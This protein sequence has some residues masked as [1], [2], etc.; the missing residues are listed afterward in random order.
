MARFL[1]ARGDYMAA[2]SEYERAEKKSPG[3]ERAL[4]GIALVHLMENRLSEAAEYMNKILKARPG[5]AYPFGILGAIADELRNPDDAKVLYDAAMLADPSEAAAY[6]RKAQ[7]L[8]GEGLEK[9]CAD[10][11]RECAKVANPRTDTPMATERLNYIF[12][13]VKA[14]RAPM[15]RAADS[16]A[17]V[18]G[19]GDLLDRAVGDEIPRFRISLEDVKLGGTKEKADAIKILSEALEA[20][21]DAGPLCVLGELLHDIGRTSDAIDCYERAM[22][23][24][25][26]DMMH[27]VYK[28]G[29]LQD[30]GDSAGAAKC[31]DEALE[32]APK[33]EPNAQ[34]QKMLRLRRDTP[35]K[36]QSSFGAE[37]MS[38]AVRWHVARRKRFPPQAGGSMLRA[39]K[40]AR[41]PG[42]TKGRTAERGGASAAFARKASLQMRKRTDEHSDK[43]AKPRR[44]ERSPAKAS[45]AQD[46]DAALTRAAA[47]FADDEPDEALRE[48]E[49]A[50][51]QSP[52]DERVLCGMALAHMWRGNRDKIADCVKQ[53]LAVRPGA[54]YPHGITGIFVDE[55]GSHDFAVR[56][57]DLMIAADPGEVSA[58]VRKAMI[59]RR[60]GMEKECADAIKE[61]LAARWS[62]RESPKEKRRLREMGENVA[63]G[64]RIAFKTHDSGTFLPGMWEMLDLAFGPDRAS[65][66][67]PDGK[68][69]FEGIRLAGEGDFQAG[70]EWAEHAFGGGPESALTWSTKGML[71]AEDGRVDEA[72]SCYERAAELDP[73]GTLPYSCKANLLADEGNLK[74]ARECIREALSYAPPNPACASLQE[75]LAGVLKL[76]DSGGEWPQVRSSQVMAGRIRWAAG[77]RSK[78]PGGRGSSRRRAAGA[79][80]IFPPGLAGGAGRRKSGRLRAGRRR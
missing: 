41:D 44:A 26:G 15:I 35:D 46:P 8:L 33:D 9:E 13:S 55:L 14:G 78:S 5:A 43:P 34:L 66:E 25:P 56:C 58:Y 71:L 38:S 70:M 12:E 3:D 76:M 36:N 77:R 52:L 29:V 48:Y 47:M 65:S 64:E 19:M 59:L 53:L 2:L 72:V 40:P 80:S 73:G 6:V 37:G 62:G 32:A 57:Y 16:V 31:L 18:P 20:R 30:V 61:C 4:C 21:P 50:K 42:R 10:L 1:V 60:K 23:Q 24:S 75:E 7:I 28:L 69:D 49:Q 45:F 79:G 74:G 27:Y 22:K 11:I 51:K 17:F 68:L 63:K 67:A 54:G 39:A